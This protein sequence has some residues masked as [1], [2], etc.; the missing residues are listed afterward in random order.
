MGN[1]IRSVASII[2]RRVHI[3]PFAMVMWGG[4]ICTEDVGPDHHPELDLG[5]E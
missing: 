1:G 2:I 5:E 3:F 4:R